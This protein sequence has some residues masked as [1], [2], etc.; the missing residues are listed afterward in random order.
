M[1]AAIEVGCTPPEILEDSGPEP[2][3]SRR[4]P[5]LVHLWKK[6]WELGRVSSLDHDVRIV[7]ARRGDALLM[8]PLLL[9]KSNDSKQ[10][11]DQHRRILHLEFAA[12]EAPAPGFAWADPY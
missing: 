7:V 3:E 11:S 2:A 12:S 8:R 9:H 1:C 6:S 5:E 4:L 10:G